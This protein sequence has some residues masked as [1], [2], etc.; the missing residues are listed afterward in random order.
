[1][2]PGITGIAG[3]YFLTKAIPRLASSEKM[4][5]QKRIGIF[6]ERIETPPGRKSSQRL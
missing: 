5:S 4:N 6:A 2:E 3:G 1:V